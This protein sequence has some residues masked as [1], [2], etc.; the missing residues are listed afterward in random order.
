MKTMIFLF[1]VLFLSPYAL[2]QS[3][4]AYENV[5]EF[6][7]RCEKGS[8]YHE[9]IIFDGLSS[10]KYLNWT[11]VELLNVSSRYDYSTTMIEHTNDEYISCDLM[12]E[13][14][15]NNKNIA[16][17]SNYL[18]SLYSDEIRSTDSSRKKALQDFLVRMIVN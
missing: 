6:D 16:I 8:E 17:N 5:K 7:E 4:K 15:Y 12:V 11:Q 3:N 2:S 10:S 14:K 1:L 13:Y 9:N 18:V